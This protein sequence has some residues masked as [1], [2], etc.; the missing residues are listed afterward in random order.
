MSLGKFFSSW[1]KTTP[2]SISYAS[3][4]DEEL[5]ELSA[6]PDSLTP[7]ARE[8][9]FAELARRNLEPAEPVEA[10]EDVELTP[11][12]KRDVRDA[13]K[14]GCGSGGGCHGK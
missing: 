14:C 8:E 3:C 11:F 12:L 10:P 9:M 5:I 1:F 6:D 7:A 2:V 4:T 13:H